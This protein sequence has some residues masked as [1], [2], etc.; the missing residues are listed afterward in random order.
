MSMDLS[1]TFAILSALSVIVWVCWGVERCRARSGSRPS[2]AVWIFGAL[3]FAIP[4]AVAAS[5][6]LTDFSATPPRMLLVLPAVLAAAV[7]FA[8]SAW[9]KTLRDHASMAAVIGFQSFRVLP[10]TLLMLGYEEGIVPV[11]MTVEG[12]NWDIL[13]AVLAAAIYLRWRKANAGV[14]RWAAVGF[15]VVG[16]GLLDK[17]V[18][19]AVLSMPTPFRVFMNEPANTFV[20]TFPYI[21]LPA[22]HVAAAL[23]G[24][25]IVLRKLRSE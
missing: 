20:A 11:Q 12:R 18:G 5:G 14:P 19:I 17:I 22:V 3:W 16:V 15:S 21:L 1:A 9:G 10:E 6:A 4:S 13:S 25:L 2:S 7:A 8:F 24:H 23:G